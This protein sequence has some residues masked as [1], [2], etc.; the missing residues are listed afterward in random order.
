MT[1]AAADAEGASGNYGYESS[2]TETAASPGIEE[3]PTRLDIAAGERIVIDMPKGSVSELGADQPADS[4]VDEWLPALGDGETARRLPA[5][6]TD[7]SSPPMS[8]LRPGSLR[9]RRH[10]VKLR[11]A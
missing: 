11:L 3:F 8:S 10:R 9:L 4:V 6:R 1:A 5:L 2:A 7:P